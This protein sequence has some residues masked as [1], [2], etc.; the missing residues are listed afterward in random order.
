MSAGSDGLPRSPSLHERASMARS[1]QLRTLEFK[2]QTVIDVGVASETQELC[3]AFPEVNFLLIEALVEFEP[4]L[5]NICQ[6]HK[7]QYVLAAAGEASGTTIFNVHTNQ[8]DCSSLLTE[9]EGASVDG[10]PR[11]VPVV[12]ID[13]VRSEKGLKGPYLIKIDVQ[14]A[15][16]KVL[17]G[18]TR[19][20]E[21]TEV[22]ILEVTPFGTMIG[23]PQ[24]ADVVAYMN[25]HGF[26]VYDAWGFLYR[27]YDGALLQLDVAFVPQDGLFRKSHVYATPEQR[28]SI[29]ADYLSRMCQPSS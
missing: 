27:P 19:V 9:A 24:L 4:F 1:H 7:A 17:E 6:R 18:A 11:E 14:G 15:E 22:V 12:T 2:A 29:E 13:Q 10:S 28:K 26:V 3:E 16:L 21:E 25:D 5:K 8:L 23:G 20:L